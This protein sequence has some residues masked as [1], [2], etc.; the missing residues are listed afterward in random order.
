MVLMQYIDGTI[1]GTHA[2]YLRKLLNLRTSKK[3]MKKQ[4]R[5]GRTGAVRK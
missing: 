1:D 2:V 3:E 4:R 5:H